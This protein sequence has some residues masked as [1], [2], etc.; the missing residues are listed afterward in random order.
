[1]SLN[2]DLHIWQQTKY[3]ASLDTEDTAKSLNNGLHLWQQTPNHLKYKSQYALK[4]AYKGIYDTMLKNLRKTKALQRQNGSV[5]S[6]VWVK[7]R[8]C[9]MSIFESVRDTE[10][11][12]ERARVRE[13]RRQE[14]RRKR[15]CEC[16]WMNGMNEFK[17]GP[18]GPQWWI[19]P[20]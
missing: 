17:P 14:K 10:R 2:T 18:Q 13:K 7:K 6:H 8:M 12:K 1:M 4:C 20:N 11:A 15:E 16:E 3:R 19:H 5:L 9:L